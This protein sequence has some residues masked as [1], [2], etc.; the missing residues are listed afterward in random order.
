MNDAP[1]I[2]GDLLSRL[3]QFGRLHVLD[4]VTSTNDHAFSLADSREPAIVVARRQTKGRGRFRRRWFG[5]DDSLLFSLLL[6]SSPGSPELAG[7]TQLAGLGL[8]IA[9]ER[10]TGLKPQIRWPNDITIDGKK[11]A[12]ILCESR[13][14]AVVVGVGVNVNQSAFP[15]TLKETVS[16]RLATGRTW[17]KFVLLEAFITEFTLWLDRA[18]KGENQ[19]WLSA[20]KDRSAILLHRVEVKS[21]LR[22]HV[23]TVIDLDAEG[24]IL[25]RLDSG[26]LVLLSVGQVRRLR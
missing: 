24:R 22:R 8:C 5:D 15:E 14:D 18:R 20:V 13:R 16:L 9:V 12:G 19:A 26:R 25:L 7:L 21:F 4:T 11:L 3:A 23:G 2:P 1:S 10:A 17:D 6:F